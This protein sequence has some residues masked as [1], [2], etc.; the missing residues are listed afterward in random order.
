[1]R[2][3]LTQKSDLKT[4]EQELIIPPLFNDVPSQ[5]VGGI[6]AGGGSLV[7]GK[8]DGTDFIK[9]DG[10]TVIVAGTVS[11]SVV[12][13]NDGVAQAQF[14]DEVV[15]L[16]FG[17]ADTVKSTSVTAGSIILGIYESA[18]T[19]TP[20]FGSVQLVIAGSTLTATRSA[21]PAGGSSIT[22]TI[23]LLKS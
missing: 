7:L 22:Y 10:S 18:V 1:M 14:K 20:V 12:V 19:G 13:P 23:R 5:I 2:V 9:F 17:T 3:D 21:A 8:A 11:G 16:A 15:S 6:K 4:K